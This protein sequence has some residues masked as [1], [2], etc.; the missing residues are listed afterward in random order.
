MYYDI[1]LKSGK[2]L[3]HDQKSYALKFDEK[4]LLEDVRHFTRIGNKAFIHKALNEHL[5]FVS[6]FDL[7][8]LDESNLN[9]KS[10]LEKMGEYSWVGNIVNRFPQ[11]EVSNERVWNKDR[12]NLY[13]D[14]FVVIPSSYILFMNQI[15]AKENESGLSHA[16]VTDKYCGGITWYQVGDDYC[17]TRIFTIIELK[18]PNMILNYKED[19]ITVH[20]DI[21][22]FDV[23]KLTKN[24]DLVISCSIY[25]HFWFWLI[26]DSVV[27][28]VQ[29]VTIRKNQDNCGQLYGRDNI[30][31]LPK[32]NGVSIY[33]RGDH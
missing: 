16:F 29:K 33:Y 5:H 12:E 1:Q 6:S 2:H 7:N 17:S 10:L 25:K 8:E 18:K 27:S 11:L 23:V 26:C 30:F 22:Y 31:A 15:K 19:G 14:E 28:D 3:I 24:I 21:F 9:E 32:S 20:S 13:Q 4:V